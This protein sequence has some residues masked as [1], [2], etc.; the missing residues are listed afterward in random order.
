MQ[1][2]LA[3]FRS[4]LLPGFPLRR[5]LVQ[6]HFTAACRDVTDAELVDIELNESLLRFVA[7]RVCVDRYTSC[8]LR[9][10]RG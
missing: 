5:D 3:D 7:R 9:R 2:A 1:A 10:A 8:A 4:L 6:R